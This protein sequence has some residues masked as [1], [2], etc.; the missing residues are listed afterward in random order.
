MASNLNGMNE[1]DNID[2]KSVYIGEVYFA[3]LEETKG[4]S[5]FCG[6]KL[7]GYTS[8]LVSG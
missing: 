7:M 3:V 4:Y 1:T 6:Y 5:K 2:A 8:Y